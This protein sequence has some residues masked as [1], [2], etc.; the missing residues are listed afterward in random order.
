MGGILIVFGL[1][2]N[3]LVLLDMTKTTLTTKG[4]GPVTQ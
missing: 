2:L 3:V 4:E 1:L